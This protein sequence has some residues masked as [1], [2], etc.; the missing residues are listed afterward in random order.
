MMAALT[1]LITQ[2]AANLN[3]EQVAEYKEVFMLFDK[4]TDHKY[5]YK[6]KYK[7]KYKFKYKY[8]YKF[9]YK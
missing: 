9:K 7:N 5:K 2:A 3:S 6:Y 8:K 4:V 1:K